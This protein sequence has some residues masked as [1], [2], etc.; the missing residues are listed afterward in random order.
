MLPFS[1]EK[2][3]SGSAWTE[4]GVTLLQMA[5]LTPIISLLTSVYDSDY[6][7]IPQSHLHVIRPWQKSIQTIAL[8]GSRRF[9]LRQQVE[10]VSNM[11]QG[12]LSSPSI[13]HSLTLFTAACSGS[14][15][16]IHLMNSCVISQKALCRSG[17]ALEAFIIP[18]FNHLDYF[19][20]AWTPHFLT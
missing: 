13:V 8:A 17:L 16:V 14:L 7:A 15:I 4:R 10:S 1:P 9:L 6:P 11:W 20:L 18:R 19:Q 3:G 2:Q 5:R 12:G